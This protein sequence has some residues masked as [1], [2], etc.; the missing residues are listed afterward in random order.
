MLKRLEINSHVV[1]NINNNKVKYEDK[2]RNDN[3]I[4]ASLSVRKIKI[5]ISNYVE[6][7]EFSHFRHMDTFLIQS[8]AF[9]VHIF[10]VAID[11]CSFQYF[12]TWTENCAHARSRAFSVHF[13]PCFQ[14]MFT[15]WLGTI[16]YTYWH[17]FKTWT[18]PEIWLGKDKGRIREE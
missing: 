11:C 16:F 7:I 3:F 5:I 12:P 2:S 6:H 18:D 8:R 1:S 14:S 4:L 15:K 9:S 17:S 10:G 13:S